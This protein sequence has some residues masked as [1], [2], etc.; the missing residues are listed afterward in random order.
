MLSACKRIC[1]YGPGPN[2]C[3]ETLPYL[4]AYFSPLFVSYIESVW[5]RI[6]SAALVLRRN[7]EVIRYMSWHEIAR[8][9]WVRICIVTVAVAPDDL[10]GEIQT[11]E[12]LF[13]CWSGIQALTPKHQF[14]RF[15]YR[16]AM[17]LSLCAR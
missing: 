5:L 1:V 12:A 6:T 15:V 8:V 4:L 17:A 2:L 9:G 16:S 11:E 14:D 7:A 10:Q 3:I 13:S